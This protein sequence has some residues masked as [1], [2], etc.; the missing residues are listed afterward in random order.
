MRTLNAD[1]DA[2]LA[3]LERHGSR[4]G[5]DE[6]LPHFGIH[7]RKAFGVSVPDI[8]KLAKILGRNHELALALWATG[9]Q[10]A[11]MLASLIDE[12]ERLTPAQMDRWC[13]DFDNWG[14]C[15]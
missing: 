9:W 7:A 14:I 8:R 12:P 15:D 11:R 10:E 3:W 1:V 2:A 13:R 5:R 4:K 6:T